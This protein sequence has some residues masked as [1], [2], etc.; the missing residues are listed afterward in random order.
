MRRFLRS[1]LFKVLIGVVL[2]GFAGF[3]VV[4]PHSTVGHVVF[5]TAYLFPP[6]RPAFL[7][8]YNWSLWEF[9]GGYLTP[10]IDLFLIGRLDNC[11][12]TAEETAIIDFQINQGSGRWGDALLR[13]SDKSQYRIIANIMARIDSMD[14]RRTNSALILIEAMRR[15]NDLNKGYFYSTLEPAAGADQALIER[16]KECFKNW[17]QGGANWPAS[18]TENPLEGTEIVIE[19]T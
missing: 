5:H 2:C 1:T 9:E 6:T 4:E 14:E 15:R 16:A 8:F 11:L 19:T 12:G 7:K 17:W 13:E 18:R 10:T 3:G